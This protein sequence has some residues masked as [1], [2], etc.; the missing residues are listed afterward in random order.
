M[1]LIAN[2]L[3]NPWNFDA[4]I[5]QRARAEAEVTGLN[6]CPHGYGECQDGCC[7]P[8]RC[9]RFRISVLAPE[10]EQP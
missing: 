2:I 6:Y 3:R 1:N 4:Q 9:G 8:G 10:D 7:Y 5:L